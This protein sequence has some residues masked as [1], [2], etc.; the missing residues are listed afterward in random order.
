MCVYAAEETAMKAM[1]ML[2]LASAVLAGALTAAPAQEL[3]V[4]VTVREPAGLA[5]KNEPASGGVPFK[6]GQV[7]D[8]SEL[9]LFN[10]AG[11]QVAAQFTKLAPYEDRSVQ[12]AL[13]DLVVAEL[14]A[15]GAATFVVR[16]AKAT[17]P[18]RPLEVRQAGNLMSV[19]TR[20][21]AFTVD[22]SSANILSEARLGDQAVTG[23]VKA[24]LADKTGKICAAGK[25]TRA[26]WEVLGPVRA[27]LRFEGPFDGHPM[28]T[29]TTRVTAWAGS[30]V[31]RIDHSIR[32]S[33]PAQGDD[34]KM[35]WAKVT[36]DLGFK[37]APRGSGR[38]WAA[39]GDG[40]VGALVVCRHTGGCFPGG[41]TRG[42]KA[43]YKV[44]ADAATATAW[45]VP[46]GPGGKGVY[47]YGDGFFALADCAH[48]DTAIWLDL[49][50]GERSA[51]A[52]ADRARSMVSTLHA[53]ADPAWISET[54]A[55]S[56][57]HF[58]TLEDEI[59]CYKRWGWKGWDD[60][61]KLA[62]ARKPHDPFAY[63]PHVSVHNDSES[64][65]A[66][67]SL[68]MYV[69]TGER[70]W[71]DQG[72]AW[73]RYYKSHYT[74]RT[75]RFDYDG[76]RHVR[77]A[78]SAKSKRPCKGQ[79]FG[80]YGP[81]VYG[82]S[83][84]RFC[85][86]HT[87][88]CG[89]FDYY[90]LT[91]DVDALEGGLD[92]AEVAAATYPDAKNRPGT[93]LGLGRAWGRQ[94]KAVVRA[95]QVTRKPKWRRAMNYFIERHLKAPNK[96]PCGLYASTGRMG[97]F[98]KNLP[99]RLRAYCRQNGISWTVDK[100]EVTV[101]R[102]GESWKLWSTCQSFEFAACAEAV[103]RCAEVTGRPEM[104]TLVVDLARGAR[105]VYWSKHC[106]Q[107]GL[108][109]AVFGFPHKDKAYD[110]GDWDDAHKNCPG[111]NGGK[112]SGY[113]TRFFCDI[114]ARAY[115]HTGDPA[116]LEF[117]RQVW[118]RGSKRGYWTRSQLV[119]DDVVA[120]FAGH[121]PPQGDGIDIRNCMRLFYHGARVK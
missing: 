36:I 56:G 95:Y 68:L 74:F 21:V 7:K 76:F 91:G 102:G 46:Q 89:M 34:A 83:D 111:P 108:K 82:W 32:N 69:R 42:A 11:E 73:A 48:K 30:N 86:C 67:L 1:A 97:G 54:A 90:C 16:R 110:P 96:Q 18:A 40:K 51:A 94:F 62:A 88:S 109:N 26:N 53:L 28:L 15:N 27:T 78:V 24:V 92:M 64:D 71:L 84:S 29:Y 120:G 117:A 81:K 60:P 52:N 113:H 105:D 58:G 103:A 99:P 70:G 19:D 43:R 17:P 119:P 72:E 35:K 118:N 13:L 100:G 59:A 112:H 4:K 87:W 93:P 12:W 10:E 3:A 77:S 75:D 22:L 121:R 38:N 31:V 37:G 44:E 63:V 39:S 33:N 49:H 79:A 101:T 41:D 115:T 8:V 55:L 106:R 20:A 80:W 114:C 104:K 85:L 61:K 107:H 116:W 57:G 14:P 47:G 65:C 6:R 50:A 66:E 5:R 9:A 23:A 98:V 45:T 25:P 2:A